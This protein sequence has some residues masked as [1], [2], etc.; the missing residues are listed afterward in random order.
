MDSE[1]LRLNW[2]EATY[3]KEKLKLM[4]EDMRG[5]WKVQSAHVGQRFFLY[6]V[7]TNSVPGIVGFGVIEEGPLP[8]EDLPPEDVLRYGL[9]KV[10]NGGSRAASSKRGF[11]KISFK[12]IDLKFPV[13]SVLEI[14]KR[15]GKLTNFAKQGSNTIPHNVQEPAKELYEELEIKIKA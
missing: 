10:D 14:R 2:I 1:I 13:A 3:P 12:A 5:Y 9:A 11:A 7:A 4:A 15:F 8:I 6:S